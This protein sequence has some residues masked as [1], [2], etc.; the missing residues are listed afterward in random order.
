M[1]KLL[2]D[3]LLYKPETT[4]VGLH[5]ITINIKNLSIIQIAYLAGRD[6]QFGTEE[7]LYH[8]YLSQIK[9]LPDNKTGMDVTKIFYNLLKKSLQKPISSFNSVNRT[10]CTSIAQTVHEKALDTLKYNINE[11]Q[12]VSIGV[13]ECLS[14]NGLGVSH[15]KVHYFLGFLTSQDQILY[16]LL[17]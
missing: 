5:W 7:R 13:M 2:N 1:K 12:H 17:Q 14:K 6:L 16:H 4:W 11:S 10:H 15:T 8:L 3:Q 9:S